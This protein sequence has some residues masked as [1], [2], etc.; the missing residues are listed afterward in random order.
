[1][2]WSRRYRIRS[3][4]RSSLWIV[5]I[6]AIVLEQIFAAFIHALDARYRFQVLGFGLEVAKVIA[7]T[8]ITFSL[9]F[10]VFTFGSLLVAVQV[11]SG[12]RNRKMGRMNSI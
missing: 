1:M 3:Y 9:S 10:V 12:N 6:G 8:V 5:P 2:T 11:A 7:S 4:L